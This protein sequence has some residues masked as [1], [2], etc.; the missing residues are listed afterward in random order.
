MHRSPRSVRA[1]RTARTV[2]VSALLAAGVAAVPAQAGAAAALVCGGSAAPTFGP[3]QQNST[4]N[5]RFN[6]YGNSNALLDDWTGADSTYSVRL[7]DG[8]VVF[9]FSDTFLGKVNAGSPPSRPPVPIEGG[10]TPFVNNTFVVQS[11][12][13]ALT[14]A[15]GGTATAPTAVLPPRDDKHL[16]WA[17]DMTMNGTQLQQPYREYVKTGTN[18]W[19]IAWERN[20][21]AKFSTSNLK[22]PT[23]V[24]PLP[25]ATGTMWGSALLKDGGKTYIY[26]TEDRGATKYL[27]VARV[28]GTDLAGTWEY[29]ASNG[30]WSKNETDSIRVM[31]GVSNEL[32]VTRRG[33]FY[34]LLT[35]D[36]KQAFSGEI[37]TY[38]SCSPA[39]AFTDERTVYN[40]PEGGPWGSYGDPDVYTYNAHAHASLSSSGKLVVSYNVNSLDD[41]PNAQKDVYRDV[42]IY[43][44]RFIDVPVS[45]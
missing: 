32:S 34:I 6:N 23:S 35:Q 24:T 14:T 15:H 4:L 30:L 21:L 2:L 29:L 19:D 18:A 44:P 27:R 7:P 39:G 31:S 26:G 22:A 13:G 1:V 38:L 28:E 20:V 40:T 33:N 43:R 36:T 41:Q 42:T 10:D 3:A 11:T 17:G 16:Y 12:T 9:G 5:S 37:D 45:G 8:R 25:S